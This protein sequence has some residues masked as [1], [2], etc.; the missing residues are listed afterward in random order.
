MKPRRSGWWA[1]GLLV[2]LAPGGPTPAQMVVD[3]HT[4][5]MPVPVG[6]AYEIREMAVDARVRDQVAEVQVSQTFHNPG[7][8]TIEAEYLFPLPDDAGVQNL[9]LM[10]DGHELPGRL[11]PKDEARRIYEEIVRTKRDPALLEYMGRGLFRAS[12]FPIPA[13]QD[14]KV[15]LRYTQLCRR[16]RDVVEFAYPLA[17]QKHSARAIGKLTFTLR[18]ENRDPIKSVYCPSHDASITR[19]GEREVKA[20]LERR[21]VIPTGDFRLVYT[22]AEG[23]LGATV[24]SYRP[25]EGEDGY[26][27][28]LASPR[29]KPADARPLPKTVV[30]V[31]D[32]S[33]SM[34]GKKLEQARAALQSVLNNLRDDDTFNI[35]AYDDRVEAFK[36]ELQRYNSASRAEAEKFVANIREGGSTNIDGAL[37]AALAMI[38]DDSR[39]NYVLF[40]T[41]G[42]PTAGETNELKIAANGRDGNRSHARL[43]SFGVGFDVNARLLDRLSGGNGG[44]SEYVRPDEDIEAHVGA[45]YAKITRPAFASIAVEMSGTDVNRTYPRDVPDLFEGGQ[46]V[47]V[48]RYSRGGHATVRLSGKVGGERRSFEFPAELAGP[49]SSS[50]YDF[51]E[52]LWAVRRVGFI[53]DQIDLNGPNRELTDEL[54]SLSKKYGLLTPYTSFLADER[55][56][57]HASIENRARATSNLG[58]LRDVQGEAGV[59][60]RSMKQIYSNADSFEGAKVALAAPAGP[61]G[62]VGQMGG[63]GGGGM[64]FGGQPSKPGPPGMGGFAGGGGGIGGA[65]IGGGSSTPDAAKSAPGG[66][67]YAANP[68]I[69]H[70]LTRRTPIVVGSSGPGVPNF[71]QPPNAA[72]PAGPARSETAQSEPGQNVRQMGNKTFY[73]KAER[74]VDSE[75]KPEED[76]RAIVLE[77][78]SDEFFKVARAQSADQNQYFSFEEPV[79]VAIE[80]RVY[81]IEPPKAK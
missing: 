55:V 9:V 49:G 5:H 46:L 44:T 48:G 3:R 14:R 29:V 41:D 28:L 11:L 54:V 22:V 24:L 45:F 38:P 30:F 61:G 20:T 57:L 47:W 79:T 6:R 15:T 51:V 53:I 69:D 80:G 16:D 59:S 68:F 10:V 81:R 42:L 2:A 52:K 77:Q 34:A 4:I 58:A 39:P 12:V 33:G 25:S 35:V 21:D 17:T 19:P 75:V 74:W 37:K 27:L 50:G 64:G 1:L 56:N 67:Q 32:R 26:F 31:I 71:G 7:S 40:L 43:F 73:R 8:T 70:S 78:F 62:M 18:V 76:A 63:M 60:Q 72:P 36:P 13:G 65:G 23:A 66:A